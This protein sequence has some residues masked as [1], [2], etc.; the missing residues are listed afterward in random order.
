[1][2]GGG[3]ERRGGPGRGRFAAHPEA[4]SKV[5]GPGQTF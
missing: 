3:T 2:K 4:V 5:A 1:M